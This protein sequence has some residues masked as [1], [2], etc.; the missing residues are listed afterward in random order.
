MV[1][2]PVPGVE[3][4]PLRRVFLTALRECGPGI[5]PEIVKAV[6]IKG[7]EAIT[8]KGEKKNGKKNA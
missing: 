7:T 5:L 4:M 8:G 2:R 1:E 6:A 3:Q